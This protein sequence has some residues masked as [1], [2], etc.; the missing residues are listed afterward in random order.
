MI[1]QIFKEKIAD[2]MSASLEL[3]TS[4]IDREVARRQALGV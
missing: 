4:K 3:T 2:A 1:L